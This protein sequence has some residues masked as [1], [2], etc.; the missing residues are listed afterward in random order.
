MPT[1]WNNIRSVNI[2]SIDINENFTKKINGISYVCSNPHCQKIIS[3]AIDPI[4]IANDIVNWKS[5]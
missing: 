5:I 2:Q 1:L 4:A 3:V